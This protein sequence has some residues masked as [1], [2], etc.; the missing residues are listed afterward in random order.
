MAT[1]ALPPRDALMP[2]A[3]GGI[4]RGL[5]LALLAHVLLIVALSF[6]VD[7]HASDSRE[8][9]EAELWAAVPQSAA[10]Q[11][12]AVPTPQPATPPPPAPTRAERSAPAPAP[13]ERPAVVEAP[14]DAQIAIERKRREQQ[15]EAERQAADTAAKKAAADRARQQATVEAAAKARDAQRAADARRQQADAAK[16]IEAQS[17]RIEKQRQDN[18]KRLVGEAGGG[19]GAPTA[20]GTAAHGAGPSADYLGRIKGRIRPNVS[21]P[22]IL[23]GNPAVEIEV[24]VA[25]DGRIVSSRVVKRSGSP[26]WDDAV[27]RAIDKTEVLPRDEN[28]RAPPVMT[29][30]YRPRD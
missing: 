12:A 17:V 3:P 10:P 14:P 21:F 27:L 24:R 2:Q 29:I 18:L 19:S 1:L 8:A 13:V 25:P 6:G 7:W 16:Q 4:G 22:N 28:G 30:V 11:A 5:L 15:R 9:A 23:D 20:A 26:E